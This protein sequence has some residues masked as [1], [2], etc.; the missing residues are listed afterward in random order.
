MPT[1]GPSVSP[2]S[3]RITRSAMS[4]CSV[5]SLL[6]MT[7]LAPQ[8]LAISG[9]PAAGHTTS[10]DPIA[11]NRSQCCDKFRGAAHLVFRHRLSERDGR[12]LDRIVADRAVGRAA[13]LVEARF[14]PRQIVGLPAA[15]AAGIGGVA[16]QLDHVV[17]L[18]A[19][20]LMQI[21]DVLGDDRGDLAGPVERGQRA[22][23]AAGLCRGKGRLHRKAPPP[24]L[25]RA[26]RDWRR[27]R[28]TGS[29]GCG[30]TTRPASGNRECRIRSRCRRR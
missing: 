4:S 3:C 25:R 28:R 17:G 18:E 23:A 9:K 13:G 21:V 8:F 5:G 27:T 22:V 24:G 20:H 30:S 10:E 6:M 2:M 1:N 29:D 19:R 11:R 7:S 14:D 15:D 26:R 16:V 12:G